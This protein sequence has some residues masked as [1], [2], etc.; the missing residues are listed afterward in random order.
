LIFKIQLLNESEF[1]FWNDLASQ[2]L[3]GTL[4]HKTYWLDASGENFK[5]YGCFR[6]GNLVGGLPIG[7]RSK[8][9]IR[10]AV[11]PHLTPYLGVVF[12]KSETKYVN[13]TSEEKKISESIAKKIK[14]DFEFVR[15]NFSPLF[16]DLQPFIWQGF[17]SHVRYTYLL[18]LESLGKVWKA[19][20]DSRRNDVRRAEKDGIVVESSDN[21]KEAFALVEKTFQ[22]QDIE[23]KFRSIAFRY[24]KVLSEKGQ[25]KSFLARNKKGKAIAVVYI[26]WDKKRSYYLLGGYDFEKRHHGA[27]AI[28]TWEAIKFTKEKLGLN[29]FDF[30]GSMIPQVE[31]FFRKFGGELTPYYFVTWAKPSVKIVLSAKET[32]EKVLGR[33]RLK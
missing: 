19:M 14:E 24:N 23:L 21:F 6:N 18:N 26:V 3:Q 5:I 13:R 27:S 20:D 28:A 8:F 1:P 22:R 25:C 4:F 31:Q 11:H 33:L 32:V 2:S 16:T 29:E 15:F 10:Q 30:E 12:K 9:G 7:C 17:S